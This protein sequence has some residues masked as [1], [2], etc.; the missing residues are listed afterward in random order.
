MEIY[1]SILPIYIPLP[2]PL[3]LHRPSVT[4]K[5]HALVQTA[6]RCTDMSTAAAA[7]AASLASCLPNDQSNPS[8]SSDRKD[9]VRMADVR[10]GDIDPIP[11]PIPRVCICIFSPSDSE[12]VVEAMVVA[13]KAVVASIEA[14]EH[15]DLC[16]RAATK[17]RGKTREGKKI[18]VCVCV[19]HQCVVTTNEISAMTKRTRP[20]QPSLSTSS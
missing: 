9:S 12:D 16:V 4:S 3:E 18:G 5:F 11:I 7:A 19:C 13:I 1:Y 20:A 6:R 14:E 8:L 10:T 17:G 2:F 15:D